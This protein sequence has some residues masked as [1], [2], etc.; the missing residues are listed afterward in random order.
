MANSTGAAGEGSSSSRLALLGILIALLSVSCFALV[1]SLTAS[2][3]LLGL[4]V[5]I[6]ALLTLI[7]VHTDS[8]PSTQREYYESYSKALPLA[9]VIL[10]LLG[11]IA[12]LLTM[13]DAVGNVDLFYFLSY[14]RD[15]NLGREVS[16]NAYSYFPGV[17]RFWQ[18]ALWLS[19]ESLPALKTWHLGVVGLN[20]LLIATLLWRLTRSLLVALFA[21]SWALLLY[22]RFQGLDGTSEPLATIPLLIAICCW[23][24]ELLQGRKGIWRCLG[25][26]IGIGLALYCK[27]QAGLLSIGAATLLLESNSDS[28]K[29]RRHDLRILVALPLVALSTLLL[30]ILAEGAELAPLWK[31]LSTAAGYGQEGSWLHNIYVQLRRDETAAL[32]ALLAV[33]TICWWARGKRTSTETEQRQLSIAMMLALA[34]LATLIQLRSR[35]FHHYMLLAIPSLVTCSSLA[36]LRL[37]SHRSDSWR[38]RRVPCLALL[39]LPLLPFLLESGIDD[40]FLAGRIPRPVEHGTQQRWHQRTLLQQDLERIREKL[41]AGTSV[42]LVPA[43]H[44][45]IHFLLGTRSAAASGYGFQLKDYADG[46]WID[47]LTAGHR[48]LLVQSGGLDSTDEKLWGRTQWLVATRK[49]DVSNYE[50]LVKGKM[51]RLYQRSKTR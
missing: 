6:V 38:S 3:H 20:C 28:S 46:S 35:A 40:G 5:V 13:R 21:A 10:G 30:A 29:G 37:W 50:L 49:L 1:R 26:G 43:R 14:A 12:Y 45:S 34:G 51:L 15:M 22:S 42:L 8:F 48:Y 11:A 16:D 41:P 44:N 9:A 47:Q 32:A 7:R 2:H 39:I 23:N 33:A 24:G 25:L 36:W 27:Q 18:S 17:Y 31:G 19:G 4:L